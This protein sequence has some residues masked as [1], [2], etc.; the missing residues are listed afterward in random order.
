M[1]EWKGIRIGLMGLAEEDWITTLAT[2]QPDSVQY[3]DYVAAGTQLASQL[4]VRHHVS[5][6]AQQQ[7]LQLWPTHACEPTMESMLPCYESQCHCAAALCRWWQSAWQ[8]CRHAKLLMLKQSICNAAG[9][10]GRAGDSTDTHAAA[11]RSQM[12]SGDG[13]DR[14]CAG[15]T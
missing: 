3:T 5:I 8:H 4:R 12:C 7:G 13:G 2:V 15:R 6:A 1:L 11:Q 9:A 14:P 10:G